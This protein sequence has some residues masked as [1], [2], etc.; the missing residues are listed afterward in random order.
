MSY[1]GVFM[2][3]Q[4]VTADS[5]LQKNKSA[6]RSRIFALLRYDHTG[7]L[8]DRVLT[9]CYML[10]GAVSLSILSL[11][12]PYGGVVCVAFVTALVAMSVFEVVRLFARDSETMHYRPVAGTVFFFV[13]ALPAVVA[14]VSAVQCVVLGTVWW[15]ALYVAQLVG[16]CALMVA[17]VVEGRYK[18]E[19]SARFSEQYIASF[20]VVGK[21]VPAIIVVSGLLRGLQ[22]RMLV[23]QTESA[24]GITI[25]SVL[26]VAAAQVGDLAKSYLKRLRGVKDLGAIFPGHGGVLDRFDAMIAAAPVALV[27]LS[28]LGVF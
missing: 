18:L 23:G 2:S 20:L 11:K 21:R 4:G 10:A 9:A 7:S 24:W 13:L 3:L 17:L 19:Q 22:R 5:D 8:K 1:I 28:L 15:R 25:T 16:G 26:V 12:L 27:F 14:A 6:G